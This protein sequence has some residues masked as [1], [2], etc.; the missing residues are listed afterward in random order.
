MMLE[1]STKHRIYAELCRAWDARETMPTHR[2]LAE[3]LHISSTSVVA[4]NL[5]LLE[6]KG[7]IETDPLKARAIRVL[8]FRGRA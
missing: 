1:T 8:T 4:Y 2:E 7:L 3:R 5:G 6:K